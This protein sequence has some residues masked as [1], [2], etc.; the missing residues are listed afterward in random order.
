[1]NL[2][3]YTFANREFLWLLIAVPCLL[4]YEYLYREK[5]RAVLILPGVGALAG[6]VSSIRTV[7]LRLLPVLRAFALSLMIIALA[8]PQNSFSNESISTEGIDIISVIDVSTSMLAQDFRPN[9]IEAAKDVASDFVQARPNDHIGL[10][11]F[12][13]ESFTL[14]PATTDHA[15]L[16]NLIHDI[17]PG[18]LEDGTAIGMGLG[19]AVDR[20]RSSDAKSRVIILLTD[21]VNNTGVIDPV[22]ATDIAV[23]YGI[24]VYC[25]GVGTYGMAPYPMPGGF[26]QQMEVEI[27]EPLMKKIS[28]ATG[29]RYFRATDNSSLRRIY[30]EIDKLEKT[31]VE[32]SSFH[33][34]SEEFYWLALAACAILLLELLLRYTLSR[35]L[36]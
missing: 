19:T 9:R 26:T 32:V 5:T 12:A 14:C 11:I 6:K 29:G 4:A 30:N 13:G 3:A 31:R 1:M 2:E 23:K 35:S 8:R 10:V 15:V 18:Q 22:T 21:G 36:S 25:I 16:Q 17:E 28:L 24:R 33:H 20:L 34:K 27:D 7:I